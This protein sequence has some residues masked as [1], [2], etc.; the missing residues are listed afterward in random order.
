MG[1]VRPARRCGRRAGSAAHRR[2]AARRPRR[3]PGRRTRA[4]WRPGPRRVRAP[5][6]TRMPP[7]ASRLRT[8]AR[9]ELKSRRVPSVRT[10]TTGSP[11]ARARSRRLSY[12]VASRRGARARSVVG[13]TARGR[14]C[15]LLTCVAGKVDT[16]VIGRR[17]V[18][19]SRSRA[20]VAVATHSWSRPS[21][22]AMTA[23]PA[24]STSWK[25]AQT[26]VATWSVSASRYQEPPPGSVTRP[27]LASSARRI[28]VLRASRRPNRS[29]SPATV[30]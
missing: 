28:W 9:R 16:P 14:R 21:A 20:S 11:S 8:N 4:G 19:R 2:R 15:G 29:G 25:R 22:R 26:S 12:A 3:P 7:A 17:R 24:R 5:P 23:P 6:W 1:I 30:S 27:T 13:R 10:R 18:A